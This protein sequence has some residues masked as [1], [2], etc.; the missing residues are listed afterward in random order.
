MV[1]KYTQKDHPIFDDDIF[2][3]DKLTQEQRDAQRLAA[4][5]PIV[6]NSFQVGVGCDVGC[7]YA[8]YV[9]L[10]RPVMPELIANDIVGVQPLQEPA[11]QLFAMRARYAGIEQ[12][13]HNPHVHQFRPEIGQ[14]YHNVY[15]NEMRVYTENGW[16]LIVQPE[17]I[18]YT[19]PHPRL[20][21]ERAD[22]YTYAP[23]A[24]DGY[25]WIDIEPPLEDLNQPQRER[26]D[27]IEFIRP[28]PVDHPD[29]FDA[30]LIERITRTGTVSMRYIRNMLGLG[31]RDE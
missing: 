2:G 15:H 22:P 12:E 28:N 19:P 1:K 8:P 23:Q 17:P 5:V 21:D 13:M 18:P 31:E 29:V 9:P 11:G 30:G 7:F 20:G 16:Q 3:G 25:N 10:M 4:V 27:Q 6:R 26:L 14:L 24:Y